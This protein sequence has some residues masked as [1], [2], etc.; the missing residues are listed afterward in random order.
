MVEANA[1]ASSILSLCLHKKRCQERFSSQIVFSR[2]GRS[3]R[4]LQQRGASMVLREVARSLQND[5]TDDVEQEV[6]DLGLHSYC[7]DAI[8]RRREAKS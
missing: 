8:K 6:I 7:A 1:L 3:R 2:N 5:S 4:R